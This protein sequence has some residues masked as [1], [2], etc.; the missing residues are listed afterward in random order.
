MAPSLVVGQLA[1][2]VDLD[3]P[4]V[5]RGRSAGQVITPFRAGR[6][7]CGNRRVGPAGEHHGSIFRNGLTLLQTENTLLIGITL[8]GIGKIDRRQR[9]HA[10]AG[11][12][13]RSGNG[14]VRPSHRVRALKLPQPGLARRCKRRHRTPLQRR[15]SG[16]TILVTAQKR[17]Q[18]LI[19]VPQSVTVV[20]GATLEDQHADSVPGLPASSFPACSSTRA[21]PGRAA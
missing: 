3:G 14:E 4:H 17:A 18:E 12:S 7:S 15:T 11:V 8:S 9:G 6:I 5:P 2:I 16:E 20:S 13:G 1:D 19:D 21:V 10:S